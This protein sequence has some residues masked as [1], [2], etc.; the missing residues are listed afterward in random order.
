MAKLAEINAALDKVLAFSGTG[1]KDYRPGYINATKLNSDFTAGIE[2]DPSTLSI[3][4][5]NR[6]DGE[7]IGSKHYRLTTQQRDKVRARLFDTLWPD[8]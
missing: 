5:Y 4:V 2:L 7:H 6:H 8:T 1:L 3:N